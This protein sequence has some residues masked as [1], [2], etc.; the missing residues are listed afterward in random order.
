V[1][2]GLALATYVTWQ[3]AQAER[4]LVSAATIAVTISA[5]GDPADPRFAAPRARMLQLVR[6]GIAINPHYRKI[7]PMVADE[8]AR[9]GDW[10]DALWIWQSVLA[11]RPNVVVLLTNV[12]RAYDS[13]G[14]REEAQAY[15]ERARQVQPRAPSVRSLE[16]LMLARGG[17]EPLALRKGQEALA[18]G[19]VDYDL[20]NA[21][22]VLALRARNYALAESLLERRM[23]EWPESRPRGLVELG[24]LQDQGFN[25][26]EKAL[27]S[28]RQGLAT[29]SSRERPQLLELVPSAYQAQLAP[30]P[31]TSANSK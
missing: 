7:T 25:A 14:R 22:F 23:R 6:E 28:F 31:Q 9:W 27:A 8:L 21:T 4:K 10:D 15:L 20:V 26:P 3:A 17:Q 12:A 5:T 11:S 24:L 19:I 16:V 1:A 2:A 30:K 29:A 13:L 18:Q